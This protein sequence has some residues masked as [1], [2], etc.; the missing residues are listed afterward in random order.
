VDLFAVDRLDDERTLSVARR[1]ANARDVLIA[2]P[3]LL[4]FLAFEFLHGCEGTPAAH[5]K[6]YEGR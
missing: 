6:S 5:R 4:E 2:D 3:D 1:L